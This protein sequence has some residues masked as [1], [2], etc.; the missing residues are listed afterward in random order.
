DLA[1]ERILREG[2]LAAEIIRQVVEVSVQPLDEPLQIDLLQRV[3]E[4]GERQGVI[5]EQRLLV[6]R[7]DEHL[8][9]RQAGE[10]RRQ[11]VQLPADEQVGVEGDLVAEVADGQVADLHVLRRRGREVQQQR[12]V[13]LLGDRVAARLHDAA[14]GDLVRG[15]VYKAGVGRQVRQDD[16]G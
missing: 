15:R 2:V 12:A 4:V 8:Q 6:R 3:G 10:A 9:R 11:Q 14:H 1:Q 13:G 5:D 7:I 16:A